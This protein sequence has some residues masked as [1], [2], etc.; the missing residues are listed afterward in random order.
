MWDVASRQP[1]GR[2][3]PIQPGIVISVAFSPNHRWL[4]AA[5]L[6]GGIKIVRLTHDVPAGAVLPFAGSDQDRIRSI[7]F[8]PDS[9][10]LASGGNDTFVRLWSVG[11]QA[12]KGAR[13]QPRRG[14][15]HRRVQPLPAEAARGRRPE[16]DRLSV[17]DGQATRH[18]D[19]AAR[20]GRDGGQ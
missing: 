10:T 2:P 17:A 8:S 16:G 5:G 12:S 11:R 19:R 4:A 6:D 9:G 15:L 14:G 7:A 13:A 3:V 1:I 18:A 20:A